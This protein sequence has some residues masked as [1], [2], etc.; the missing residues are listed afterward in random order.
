MQVA[1]NCYYVV[2]KIKIF[3]Q[4]VTRFWHCPATILNSNLFALIV[5]TDL[6]AHQLKNNPGQTQWSAGLLFRHT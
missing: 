6:H 3:N 5:F 2:D 1:K 4:T